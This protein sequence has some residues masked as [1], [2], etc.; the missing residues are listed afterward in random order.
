VRDVLGVLLSGALLGAAC[1]PGE[2]ADLPNGSGSGGDAGSSGNSGA[3]GSSA[4]GGTGAG[5]TGTGGTGIAGSGGGNPVE[6]CGKSTVTAPLLRRLTR[7]ELERSLTSVFPQVAG[8]WVNTLASDTVTQRGFDND[9]YSLLVSKQ[10]AREVGE[11]AA[12]LAAAVG[13]AALTQ[14][15]PCAASAPDAGCAG[16]FIDQYGKRLFR[17][18][19]KPD[20]RARYL[21]FF[22]AATLAT[23][24]ARGI[25]WVTRA[26]VESPAFVYRR[27]IG[28]ASGQTYRLSS[29]EVAAEL[30]Y[31][32]SGTTPTDELL[33]QADGWEARGTPPTA[34]ELT[35]AAVALLAAPG[36][37]DHVAHFFESWIGYQRAATI[38]KANVAEYDGLRQAMVGETKRFL[39]EVVFARRGGVGELLTASFTTPTAPLAAFYGLP[40]PSADFAVVERPAGQGIGLLAQASVLSSLAQPDSSSPTKRGVLV[41]ERLLCREKPAL[42]GNVPLPPNPTPAQT[43]RERYEMIH[44]SAGTDC[45]GCHVMFDPIGYGF[46]HFDEV[47]RYRATEN[48]LPIN[49][50]SHVPDESGDPLFEFDGQEALARGLV[51]VP[52]VGACVSGQL[53]TWVFGGSWACLGEGRRSDFV[54]GTLGFIDYLSS[55]AGEPQFVERTLP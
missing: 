25:G 29:Y 54:G 10:T 33:T 27:E 7:G 52:T 18:P 45:P 26:L 12:N 41:F 51:G 44:T 6:T 21:E 34:E 35:Q 42:P 20:E 4:T 11:T 40:S 36:A 19:M 46:E 28:V 48:G 47:G 53:T 9:A 30:A 3:S 14:I 2:G 49:A 32:F 37:R 55:L 43:T 1:S 50:A 23:D 13:G 24:F 38:T 16:Q 5:G 22:S 17:R 39:D 15:L 31:A 8:Q